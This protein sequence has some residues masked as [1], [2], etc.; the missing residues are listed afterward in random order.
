MA[1]KPAPAL[2]TTI[3]ILGIPHHI[4]WDA[5]DLPEEDFGGYDSD[6]NPPVLKIG[7]QKVASTLLHEIVHGILDA[8]GMSTILGDEKDEALCVLLEN[9]LLPLVPLLHRVMKARPE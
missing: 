9:G 4:V 6:A 7:A 5:Q 1:K 2:P 3:R 8:S